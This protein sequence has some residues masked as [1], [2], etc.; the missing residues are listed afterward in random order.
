MIGDY[1]YEIRYYWGGNTYPSDK[2]MELTA[3]FYVDPKENGECEHEAFVNAESG[4]FNLSQIFSGD[5]VGYEVTAV[6]DNQS[7][8][9]FDSSNTQV[10]ETKS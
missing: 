6:P 3:S 2:Y 5:L 4:T 1:S 7:S 8:L 9:L 10:I